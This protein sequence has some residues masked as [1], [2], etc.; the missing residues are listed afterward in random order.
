MKLFEGGRTTLWRRCFIGAAVALKLMVADETLADVSSSRLPLPAARVPVMPPL[1][2]TV[3]TAGGQRRLVNDCPVRVHYEARRKELIVSP[4]G[5]WVIN[6]PLDRIEGLEGRSVD[7][8]SRLL[9]GRPRRQV[10]NWYVQ[11]PGKAPVEPPPPSGPAP[12]SPTPLPTLVVD[13]R[14][15]NATDSNPGTTEAPLRTISRA[16]AKAAAGTVIAVRPGIYRESVT[17]DKSGTPAH[18]LRLEGV[19]DSDGRM[20]V[21]SGNDLFPPHSWRPVPGLPGVYRADLFTQRLGTVSAAGR[22]LIERSLPQELK[23]G[24]CCLN[25]ASRE[26]LNLRFDG[27][28]MPTP[29]QRVG[30]LRWRRVPV[31]EEGFLD[32][33]DAADG[34]AGEAVF[35]AVTNVWVNPAER[36]GGAAWDPRFPEPITGRVEVGGEFRAARMSGASL[37]AQVNKYRVWVNGQRLPSVIY[38]TQA[39]FQLTLPHPSRNYGF[40]DR[41]ENFTLHEGWNH[42]VFQFDTTTRPEKTR[43]RFGAPKGVVGIVSS[44]VSP[45]ERSRPRDTRARPYVSEYLVLGPFPATRDLGV[46][47]RLPGDADPN[48]VAMDLAARGSALVTVK[49]DFVQVRGFEIRH[50]AQFQQRA[51]VALSG[52]GVLL[53]GCL[54]RDSEVKGISFRCDKDDHAAPTVIR[55]NWVA[56]PGNVGLGGVGTSDKLTAENQNQDVPGRSPVLLEYNT[57]VNNNWAGFPAFWESGGMKLCRLTGGVI[58]YNTIVGGSG[59]GIWL[60]WEHFGNRLEGNLFRHAWAFCIGIEASPGPNLIANNVSVDLRP[61][62]VWFRH[63]LLSWSSDRNYVLFNTIDGR[64]NPLPAWQHKTGSDGIYLGEGGA[65]RKTRWVPLRN[66]RQV[67]VN[68][69]VVGCRVAVKA[70]PA[71]L[72]AANYTERGKGATPLNAESPFLGPAQGDYRLKPGAAVGHLGVRNEYTE[73]VTHDFYGLP[74][75]PDEPEAVGAFRATRTLDAAGVSRVEVEYEDGTMT[76]LYRTNGRSAAVGRFAELDQGADRTL[77]EPASGVL[78]VEE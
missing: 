6:Y 49:G 42:L 74:R 44:A 58:R 11:T 5:W 70:K 59:P 23:G 57:I 10:R 20:P 51:Q 19:R 76:R 45:R 17:I 41:W 27:K 64:W 32:L 29:G 54:V 52:E 30:R 2:P 60:D 65:D 40:S 36:P 67:L 33:R 55:N 34:S 38:S 77:A 43:F 14:D 61:G 75:F 28:E 1:Q 31:D 69:L 15:P 35:W 71:D 46:Y 62:P 68:N 78:S 7:E 56:N 72:V 8:I 66:R 53:E 3:I 18:P 22:T 24:D 73:L 13:Q 50:G 25:R 4:C 47:V 48:T 39:D 21:I 16:V 12:V 63:A 9:F 37:S 26:F